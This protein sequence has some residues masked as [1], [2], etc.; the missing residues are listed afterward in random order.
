MT[1]KY[2]MGYSIDPTDRIY[3]KGYRFL[4]FAKSKGKSFSSKY[5]QKQPAK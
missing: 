2:R 4:F 3:V 1:C 5:R